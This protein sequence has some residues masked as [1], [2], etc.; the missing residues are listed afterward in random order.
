MAG[1][2]VELVSPGCCQRPAISKGFLD[3]AKEGGTRTMR[4][5]DDY[6]RQGIPILVCEPSCASSLTDDLPDLIDD[7]ALGRRVSACV[8][9][10]DVFL[11]AEL[12]AGRCTLPW[13]EGP[14]TAFQIL[15]HGH[16]H[17]KAL[18]GTSATLGLLRR[19]PG[20]SVELIDAG[21]CG[22][23]GSFGYEKEHYEL[24]MKI[25]EDRLFP[26]LRRAPAQA[27]IVAS[28][29]SCRHQIFDGVGRRAHHMIELVRE[30]LDLPV[31]GEVV[32]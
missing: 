12:A 19:I 28:G 31:A 16:C 21:C 15:V 27:R 6:A 17:Q 10:I 25:G 9:M 22:M 14:A 30:G 7:E 24:S 32:G 23:A 20:A 5:L 8:K 1:Y 4:N 3:A 2:A 13:M 26:A 18:Y 29:F 11:E